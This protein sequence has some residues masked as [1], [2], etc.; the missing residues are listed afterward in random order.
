MEILLTAALAILMISGALAITT[1]LISM[2]YIMWV[3]R[4]SLRRM[5]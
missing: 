3:Y 5:K 4:D 2:A 1:L